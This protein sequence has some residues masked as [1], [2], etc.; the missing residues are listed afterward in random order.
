MNRSIE[1]LAALLFLVFVSSIS[2]LEEPDKN[3][4][5]PVLGPEARFQ[6]HQQHLKMQDSTEFKESKWKHIGPFHMS[7]RV[8]DI[9]KPLDKP[10]T[11]YVTSASGG[12]WKTENEGTS[13]TPLFD[14]APSAAWGA[15]AVDPNNSD[16]LWIGG[17]ESNIFRSSMAGTGVYRSTDAGETWQHMGLAD[18][19]HIAR[20]IVHPNDAD[21]VYVAAGGHE[22]TANPERGVYKTTDGGKTWKKV[23]YE[24]NMVGANDIVIDPKNP[25]N[26]F[27]SMWHRIR[28]PWSDPVPGPGGGIYKS[29][30]GGDSW[31]RVYNGLPQRDRSGRIGISLAASNPEVVYA[32]IDN[33]ETARKAKKGERDSYGR[34][35]KDVIKGAEVYRSNDAGET[36]NKV[37]EDSRLMRS[38]FS[39][40]GWVFSQIRVDPSDEDISYI[41]GVQLLK[42]TDG[43]KTYKRL[44]DRGLHA[45]HHAMWIDPANSE[46]VINGNDGGVNIT[47]D[48]GN[49]WKNIENLPVVQFYNLA[50][51]NQTPFNVYGSVQDNHSWV[52]P[53]NFR[54]GRSD[55]YLWKRAPGGEASYHQVDPDDP[56][57]LYCESFYGTLLR[58]NLETKKVT[59]IKPKPAEGQSPLRGQWLAPFQLSP[60]NSRVVYHGMHALYRSMNRGDQW[61]KISPDLTAYNADKQGNISFSTISSLSE[62]PVKF[63]LIYAGTDDG[64]IH[65]TRDSGQKWTDISE[66]LP[67]RHVSRVAASR[68]NESAVYLTLNGKRNNDFQ[69]YAYKSLDFGETWQ[70]I[71][72]GIPGGPANVIYESPFDHNTIYVGTDMGIYVSQDAGKSWQVMGSG[73]PITFV[74]DIKIHERDR[75]L[76][77]A[78]HGRGIWKLDLPE[79]EKAADKSSPDSENE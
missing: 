10:F 13:W 48:G 33:H 64:R 56:S 6:W 36:W 58:A 34:P 50:L 16:V 79:K 39:T 42:S 5:Q 9:A 52:G 27:A 72:Q 32:L 44:F 37:S 67:E 45:D 74:H 59:N 35:R 77:I 49:T 12:V 71:G 22:Y 65:V 8:T 46:Y 57:T 2:A 55:P 29:T 31:Q 14:D 41:M 17:G 76:V 15:I 62:S 19:H 20:I 23:L 40:Y 69:I 78:T 30:D 53:S 28:L 3:I 7:G 1:L 4:K 47:Y 38:L 18:T 60:H 51:D 68:F 24:S 11:F 70:D 73:L 25:D 54:S 66:G 26:L 63:G 21:T 43:G 75:T 61:E